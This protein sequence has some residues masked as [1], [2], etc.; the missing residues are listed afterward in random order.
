MLRALVV[1]CRGG[2]EDPAFPES[3]LRVC[4]PPVAVL[5]PLVFAFPEPEG[6]DQP[7]DRRGG[8]LLGD[9]WHDR[10]HLLPLVLRHLVPPPCETRPRLLNSFRETAE[11]TLD[12]SLQQTRRM[13]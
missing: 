5:H 2:Q 9:H 6:T 7:I 3:Q 1:R 8:V 10:R 13:P 11:R 4:N 12:R